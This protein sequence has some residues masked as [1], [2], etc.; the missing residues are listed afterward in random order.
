MSSQ[1]SEQE[2]QP[3]PEVEHHG[4]RRR[5]VLSLKASE[6][7]ALDD[8][9]C[10]YHYKKRMQLWE[11]TAEIPLNKRAAFQFQVQEG[12]RRKVLE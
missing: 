2:S 9:S 3:D 6:P 10:Y 7:P 5:S 12:I 11:M 1:R 8:C 4:G